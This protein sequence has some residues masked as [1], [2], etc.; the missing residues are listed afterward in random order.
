MSTHQA[1]IKI[2]ISPTF[3]GK[4][5]AIAAFYFI[6]SFALSQSSKVLVRNAPGS[7]E[8]SEMV[9][10]KWYTQHL[11]YPEGVNIYR[12]NI[13]EFEWE[14][15]N[16][17]PITRKSEVNGL[18][19]DDEIEFLIE[20]LNENSE[21]LIE[22]ELLLLNIWIKSFQDND[23]ADFL[24]IYYRDNTV[25]WNESYLYRI[26]ELQENRE[27]IIGQSDTI[28][29]TSFVPNSP[30]DSFTAKQNQLEIH[31]D[32]LVDES[33]FFAVDIYQKDSIV[34]R[35]NTN[36][37]MISLIEGED[38]SARFP[39]PK[40]NIK[41]GLVEGNSYQFYIVGLDF[42]GNETIPSD[43]INLS[44]KDITPPESPKKLELE[45]DTLL[46]KLKW[47]ESDDEDIKQYKVYR[48]SSSEGSFSSRGL[49]LG[50]NYIDEIEKP[51]PYFYYV[52]SLDSSGNE[53]ESNIKFVEIPDQF[54]PVAPSGL[55]IESDTGEFIIRWNA[56]PEDDLLGYL[57]YRTI[58][59]VDDNSVVL[60]SADP[61]AKPEYRQ[62]LPKNVRNKFFY[63]V[64][65][66]DS[67]ENRSVPSS[68]VSA[69]LPDV[70]PPESPFIRDAMFENENIKIE[71]VANIDSDLKGYNLFRTEVDQD[72]LFRINKILISP[73]VESYIDRSLAITGSYT[74]CLQAVDSS[75]NVSPMSNPFPVKYHSIKNQEEI[76]LQ[77]SHRKIRKEN[78]LT[79][80]PI[81]KGL[82]GYVVYRSEED[83]PLTPYSSI[84]IQNEFSDAIDSEELLQYQ[85]KAFM[86]DGS[87]IKSQI[88]KWNK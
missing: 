41:H 54:P 10:V 27:T 8:G 37:I 85:V 26:S 7:V 86:L 70:S 62:R 77:I 43:F 20:L 44:Y 16:S 46:V 36:P 83:E 87:I 29:I 66:Q 84:L 35:I 15:L 17:D 56:N 12:R 38:G 71:W 34:D 31:F 42:F 50:N 32:W 3:L 75:G 64:V 22:E 49:T 6:S 52:A 58:N 73:F 24:G 57:I 80:Q 45:Q 68:W 23:F 65:A 76:D 63:C 53:A 33:N 79:W 59:Q 40:Y 67:S 19:E 55:L 61:L 21:N 13:N 9:E 60:I 28:Q 30:V 72:T 14:K 25:L 88:K 78:V 39:S 69:K 18:V 47:K 82:K 11:L 4:T 48:S 74:Y 81:L 5:Y 1:S 51:G 2:E